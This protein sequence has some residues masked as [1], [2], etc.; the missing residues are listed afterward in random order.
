[1]YL[2]QVDFSDLKVTDL[3]EMTPV[4]EMETLIC[5]SQILMGTNVYA[6]RKARG[7][8]LSAFFLDSI[9]L[10]SSFHVVLT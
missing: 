7:Y 9:N 1:M 8:F 10:F 3:K 2:Q 4:H 5:C 6:C